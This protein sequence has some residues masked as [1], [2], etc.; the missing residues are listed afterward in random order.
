M[1]YYSAIKKNEFESVL[2]RF[3]N[4]GPVIQSE[5]RQKEKNKYSI[6]MNSE[7]VVIKKK[8]KERKIDRK[9]SKNIS[10][11]F[12]GFVVSILWVQFIFGS[13]LVRL[14][15]LKIYRPLPM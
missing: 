4:I 6:F 5:I 11:S 2:V 12:S 9:N 15:F 3:M 14:I 13:S 1:E 7:Y 10:R 8:K